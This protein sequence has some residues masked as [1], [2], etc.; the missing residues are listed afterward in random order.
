MTCACSAGVSSLN[1]RLLK[2]LLLNGRRSAFGRPLHR[3]ES[4]SCD[5]LG[6]SR[7]ERRRHRGRFAHGLLPCKDGTRFCRAGLGYSSS[8]GPGASLADSL[9]PRLSHRGLSALCRGRPKADLRPALM[10]GQTTTCLRRPNKAK[11][12]TTCCLPGQTKPCLPKPKFGR[13]PVRRHDAH[14]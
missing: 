10:L 2:L 9:H 5:S 4:P 12:S 6:W 7:A 8:I 3:A 11:C 14:E 13:I 1:T